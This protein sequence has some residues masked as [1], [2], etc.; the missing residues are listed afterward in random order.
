VSFSLTAFGAGLREALEAH[1]LHSHGLLLDVLATGD[2]AG[3][4]AAFEQYLG[5]ITSLHGALG[6][7][8]ER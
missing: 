3:V 5:P 2:D 7:A 6:A 4:D 1:G 8:S